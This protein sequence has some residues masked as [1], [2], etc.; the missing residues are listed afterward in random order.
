M[1]YVDVITTKFYFCELFFAVPF[2]GHSQKKFGERPR[3]ARLVGLLLALT[4]CLGKLLLP[5]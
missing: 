2:P 5:C 1:A 4:T 3:K